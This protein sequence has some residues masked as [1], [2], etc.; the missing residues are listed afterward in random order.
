[1]V[2]P[3]TVEK[4]R[5]ECDLLKKDIA[6]LKERLDILEEHS[7]ENYNAIAEQ[8]ERMDLLEDRLDR[9]L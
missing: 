9:E 8:G 3:P 4:I 6:E 2:T 7:C 1:M 5:Q